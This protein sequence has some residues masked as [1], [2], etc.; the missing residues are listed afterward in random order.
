MSKVCLTMIV[1]NEAH[2]IARCLASVR[3]LVDSYAI[4]DTGSTDDTKDVTLRWCA[5]NGLQGWYA[6]EPWKGYGPSRCDALDLAEHAVGPDGYALIVDADDIWT[7]ARPTLTENAHSVWYTGKGAKWTT[8]R[9][10]KL[11]LG[12][13][14][15]GAVH[16]MPVMPD[17]K[18]IPAP[19]LEGLT[20]SSPND[21]A[22]WRDPNKNLIRARAISQALV[23]DPCDTRYAFYLAREYRD[24][25]DDE[26]AAKLFLARAAMGLG[27]HPEEVYCSYLEAGR[28][29][30]RLGRLDDA[31]AALLKAHACCPTRREAMAELARLFAVKCATSPTVG[32]LFVE[33]GLDAEDE[34]REAAQ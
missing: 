16:E 15:V 2:V 7:G 24:H 5:Q 22:T 6:H 20:L 9:Y 8:T 12:T 1:K 10:L 27:I 29:M 11:G 34:A 23:E 13:K 21:G 31:K 4:V 3:H 18:P 26:R 30:W 25:G 33:T 17:G 19:T 14:Y 28:C 32:T